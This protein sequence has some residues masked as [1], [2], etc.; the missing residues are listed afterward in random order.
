[1]CVQFA[2]A[3]GERARVRHV[4]D[5]RVAEPPLPARLG[6]HDHGGRGKDGQR[7]GDR[8]AAGQAGHKGRLEVHADH[9]RDLEHTAGFARQDVDARAEERPKVDRD[10]P[11]TGRILEVEPAVAHDERAILDERPDRLT[12]EQWVASR[13]IVDPAGRL[14][15]EFRACDSRRQPLR[16]AGVETAQ[17]HD[18]HVLQAGPH[19]HGPRSRS[20][21]D[22]DRQLGHDRHQPFEERF[23]RWID[24]VQVVHDD[25]PRTTHVC[26]APDVALRDILEVGADACRI[27]R[28]EGRL[29]FPAGE[30][31]IARDGRDRPGV[32]RDGRLIQVRPEEDLASEGAGIEAVLI[33]QPLGERASKRVVL[34]R[35]V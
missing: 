30:L 33:G 11:D 19:R 1:M 16:T 28:H 4:M 15:A 10:A 22:D 20:G 7:P 6:R 24:P 13:S 26:E 34:A 5:E 29:R 18:L 35:R 23:A 3:G 32:A 14:V 8:C 27:G 2:P 21:K 12:D 9:G 31:G 25:H 17:F